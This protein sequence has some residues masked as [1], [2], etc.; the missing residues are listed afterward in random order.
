MDGTIY[1]LSYQLSTD[2]LISSAQ[3]FDHVLQVHCKDQIGIDFI[4]RGDYEILRAEDNQIIPRS[5]FG[6]A[7]E[8]GMKLEMSIVLWQ[9]RMNQNKCPRCGHM[10]SQLPTESGWIKWQVPSN[11]NAVC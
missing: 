6:T 5:E 10:N 3:D 2:S 9:E 11:F 8:P 4:E 1:Y 7:V